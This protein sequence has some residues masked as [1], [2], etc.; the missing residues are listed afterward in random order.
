MISEDAII[1]NLYTKSHGFIGDD[2]A[3]LP[4]L[5]AKRYVITKDL[6]I[7]DVHFRTRYF[8]PGDLAHKSLH[9]NLSDLAAM[10]AKPLYILCGISISDM[11]QQYACDFL[12]SLTEICAETKVI[13]IGGDTTKSNDQLC[14]SITAIGQV[15][16][17]DIKYRNNAQSD[18]IIC[19]A[20]NLGWAQLGF[21]ALEKDIQINPRY[22]ESFLRPQAK[23]PEG[24]WLGKQ[25]S[26]TSMMDISDGLYIDLR[27]LCKSSAKGAII[28]LDMLSRYQQTELS[29]ENMLE[30]G[31]DYGLLF[32]INKEGFKDLSE[33]FM[34]TFHYDL[35][36]VGSI[37]SDS[38]VLLQR[39]GE[40]TDLKINSF[41]HFGEKYET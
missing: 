1:Q 11:M 8:S 23:I 10:G 26:V 17:N 19:V 4:K 30:G 39:G 29:P 36:V 32:T 7:E 37:T 34:S 38:H 20:G 12:N 3:V 25:N 5:G 22:I 31:E 27:R 33:A 21:N 41:T 35:K 6:L 14:I 2:S 16:E 40:Y 13:L 9:I 15:S 18:N 24:I 28:D